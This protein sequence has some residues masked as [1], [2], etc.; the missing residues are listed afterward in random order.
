M[1]SDQI[2]ELPHEQ[3]RARLELLNLLDVIAGDEAQPPAAETIE[4]LVRQLEL[5]FLERQV[6]E[7]ELRAQRQQLKQ[8][9]LGVVAER[10]HYR[11]LFEHAPFGYLMTDRAGIIRDVNRLGARLL[12]DEASSLLGEPLAARVAS[13]DRP[14]FQRWLNE[15]GD[16]RRP[17]AVNVR[18][19]ADDEH[20]RTVTATVSVVPSE[21]TTALRWIV[22]LDEPAESA[23]S[24]PVA[25]RT[26]RTAARA[27]SSRRP[28]VVVCHPQE[29]FRRALDDLLDQTFPSGVVIT[30]AEPDTCL[31]EVQRAHADVVILGT[32]DGEPNVELI[33]KLSDYADTA[34]VVLGAGGG[35][36]LRAMGAG[37]DA[38]LS[39]EV[40]PEQVVGPLLAAMDGWGTLPPD[41]H[42]TLVER[43]EVRA[44]LL[45][46]LDDEDV[47]LLTHLAR[48]AGDDDIS[49]QLHVSTRTAKRRTAEIYRKLDVS[50][51]AEAAAIAG[52]AGLTDAM[53]EDDDHVS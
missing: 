41:L 21:V 3:Q 2:A 8:A 35:A 53:E 47:Q 32:T 44:A 29:V 17:R 45:D 23:S 30:Q 38:V 12:G 9:L 25:D 14:D 51:R 1:T 16:A 10:Q 20:A 18:V 49:R 7:E 13:E 37:A 26:G 36:A 6:A 40:A 4:R 11:E 42:R 31:T 24:S 27:P 28:R 50:G 46:N 19:G 33:A 15:L 43:E 52:R 39:G 34:I 48:G 22:A 5:S